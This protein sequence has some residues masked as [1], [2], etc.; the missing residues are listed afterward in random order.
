MPDNKPNLNPKKFIFYFVLPRWKE[1]TTLQAIGKVNIQR[2]YFLNTSVGY[3]TLFFLEY[4][5]WQY[6]LFF[7]SIGNVYIV[8]KN[9]NIGNI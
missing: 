5:Y 4:K 6:I 7:F 1:R 9:M 3:Y 2:F 8:S